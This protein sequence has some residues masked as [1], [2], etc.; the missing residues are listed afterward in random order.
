MAG[1]M[2]GQTPAIAAGGVAPFD[3]RAPAQEQDKR[4]G[5]PRASAGQSAERP[6][7]GTEFSPEER[8]YLAK[9]QARDRQVRAHEMAHVA[10]G[11]DLVRRGAQYH[12]QRGPDGVAYA[13]G[14][15]VIIDVSP[16][17]TPEET[18]R[19]AERIQAAALAPADPSPQDRAVAAQAAQMAQQARAEL[20]RQQAEEGKNE[21]NTERNAASDR[22][23][24][25]NKQDA[26]NE[27]A[28]TTAVRSHRDSGARADALSWRAQQ[29]QQY[30]SGGQ[31]SWSGGFAQPRGL[32]LRATA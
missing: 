17:R 23:A 2:P 26:S 22:P 7:T 12:Y 10:A 20:A 18:L 32:F 31:Q 1:P 29:M 24:S 11:G 28:R 21:P 6:R 8:A 13:V 15:D 3:P 19:K 4:T 9:L 5:Y 30:Y 25:Q 27:L 16:G 14:G